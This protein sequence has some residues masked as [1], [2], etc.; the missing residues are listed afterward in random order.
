MIS[1]EKAVAGLRAATAFTHTSRGD[2]SPQLIELYRP[3][4]KEGL[5]GSLKGP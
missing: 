5:A 3:A 2:V 4:I 1:N